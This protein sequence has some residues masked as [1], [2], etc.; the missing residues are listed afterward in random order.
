MC[1]YNVLIVF[2]VL[3]VTKTI[4]CV[5]W[6]LNCS[7]GCHCKW[8][9]GKKSAL[10]NSL[11]LTQLPVN[12]STEIQVLS[13][14]ENNIQTL[15]REEFTTL[16]LI[17]LQKIF[18]KKANIKYLHRETFKNL[19]ILVELDLSENQIEQLDKQTFSGNDRLRILLLYG[20]PIKKLIA[21]QFPVLPYLRTI[22]LHS[23]NIASI[24]ETSFSNVDLLEYLDLK[25]NQLSHLPGN[26]FNH[27]KNLKTLLLD[28]NPWNCDCKL[29]NFRNWYVKNN[30]NRISLQC[31]SPYSLLDQHWENIHEDAF[32]CAPILK[33]LNED[34]S[35]SDLESNITFKCF[36]TGDPRPTI[37]WHLD[38]KEIDNDNV[39]IDNDDPNGN[40]GGSSPQVSSVAINSNSVHES[41]SSS[42]NSNSHGNKIWSNLSIYNITNLNAGFYTCFARNDLGYA[43]QNVSLLLPEVGYEH[44]LIKNN[45]NFWYF[46]LVVGIFG[47]I[48]CFLLISIIFCVC[49]KVTTRRKIKKNIKGSVSFND[50]EKKLLD[51][52]ITTTNDRENYGEMLNT[53]SSAT[54]KTDSSIIALEPV[55]ITIENF[56]HHP[57]HTLPHHLQHHRRIGEEYPLSVGMFPPPPPEF[58]TATTTQSSLSAIAAVPTSSSVTSNSQLYQPM[59]AAAPGPN[60][61]NLIGNSVQNKPPYGNIFISVSLT[62][63]S[64]DNDINMYPDLLNIVPNCMKNSSTTNNLSSSPAPTIPTSQI[65]PINIESYATLPRNKLLSTSSSNGGSNTSL[66][67]GKTPVSILKQ[68]KKN[69]DKPRIM[70]TEV[71]CMAGLIISGSGVAAS[72]DISNKCVSCSLKSDNMG[73]RV[74]ASGNS[75]IAATNTTVTGASSLSIPDEELEDALE[76]ESN[77][78]AAY[79][80]H[81]AEQL[82]PPPPPSQ[83]GTLLMPNDFVSL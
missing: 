14:N 40:G 12:L 13:M 54:N 77:E 45:D 59:V 10:C 36:T 2:A 1:V 22:D 6:T 49:R 47:T 19:K 18:L 75:A 79:H 43:S 69:Y 46:G 65:V 58:C 68:T 27:M 83:A 70:E 52:S 61:N 21:D 25:Q 42:T 3:Y 23:C 41:G 26:V 31:K 63:D 55:Q 39:V 53:P 15:N 20:N 60:V 33:I 5:D 44:V 73:L 67:S 37:S 48:I 64:L 7:T 29:K 72:S 66:S 38:G 32:G 71:D 28:E 82:T 56:H 9:N 78:S 57:H 76:E 50:Q 30:L 51:L 35:L 80:H 11:N 8:M 17:N 74:T 62:Q 34:V 81:Q 16:G 24:E 4:N